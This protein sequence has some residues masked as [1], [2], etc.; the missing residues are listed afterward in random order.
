MRCHV[1]WEDCVI[2]VLT[3]YYYCGKNAELWDCF[4]QEATKRKWRLLIDSGAFSAFHAKQSIDLEAYC[5]F[6]KA[7]RSM[8][9]DYIALDVINNR[10]A[11]IRNYHKMRMH[12]LKPMAV[13]T[14]DMEVT[15][16]NDLME[17]TGNERVCVAGGVRW[18]MRA[19]MARCQLAK[20]HAPRAK[21]HALGFTRGSGPWRSGVASV[22]SSTWVNGSRFGSF[23]TFDPVGIVQHASAKLAKAPVSA[24]PMSVQQSCVRF[25]V[26]HE[27]LQS[28]AFTRRG[29]CGRHLIT[30]EAW[31]QFAERAEELDCTFFFA[32]TDPRQ[33]L[34][35]MAATFALRSGLGWQ[36]ARQL[37]KHTLADLKARGRPAIARAMDLIDR[38]GEHAQKGSGLACVRRLAQDRLSQGGGSQDTAPPRS[39][40]LAH[41]AAL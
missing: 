18:P 1:R 15:Q 10:E 39:A 22:D 40:L 25:G 14:E 26:T 27:D 4:F 41:P 7:R 8:F 9:W 34:P 30:C 36:R 17:M 19:F 2:N 11:S 12:N 38:A 35:D 3:S 6:L 37:A 29:S 21:V 33:L 28:D 23:A 32:T 31:L 13:L 5:A 20:V 24:W 16:L